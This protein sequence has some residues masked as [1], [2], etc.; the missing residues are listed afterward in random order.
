MPEEK[1]QK[2]KSEIQALAKDVA[3]DDLE[4][5]FGTAVKKSGTRIAVLIALKV[6]LKNGL[7]ENEAINDFIEKAKEDKNEILVAEASE[8]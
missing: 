6:L 5:L 3:Y 7:E 4:P 1:Q 8:I 2:V